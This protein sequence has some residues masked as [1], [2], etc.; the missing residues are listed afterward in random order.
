MD[1]LCRDT[2]SEGDGGLKP[3]LTPTQSKDSNQKVIS[4]LNPDQTHHILG[5]LIVSDRNQ[6]HQLCIFPVITIL[7]HSVGLSCIFPLVVSHTGV[8]DLG[9]GTDDIVCIHKG[10]TAATPPVP[11]NNQEILGQL[12]E[13][14]Q[15]NIELVLGTNKFSLNNPPVTTLEHFLH[16]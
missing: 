9:L 11:L 10:C 5:V 12:I 16:T 3:V 2:F 15:E 4:R 7:L 8:D 6:G 1:G 13:I 14:D